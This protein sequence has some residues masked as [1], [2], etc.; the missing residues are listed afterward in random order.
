MANKKLAVVIGATGQQGGSVVDALLESDQYAIR[1][2]TRNINSE[3]ARKLEAR[4][5]GMVRADIDNI[6]SLTSAFEVHASSPISS[7]QLLTQ[8]HRAPTQSSP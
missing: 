4:G 5:V 1:G 2:L 3:A 6:E 8:S 7:S